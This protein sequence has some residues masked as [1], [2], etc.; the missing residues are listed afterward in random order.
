MEMFWFLSFS[1]EFHPRFNFSCCFYYYML[2]VQSKGFHYDISVHSYDILWSYSSHLLPSLI[3]PSSSNTPSNHLLTFMF[4]PSLP[5][6]PIGGKHDICLPE[7]GLFHLTYWFPVPS[8]FLQ[9]MQFHS[10]WLN[11]TALYRHTIFLYICWWE[12][13]LIL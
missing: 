7:F 13:R 4:S 11:N 6:V 3:L 8:I 9:M 1:Q 10:L 5:R 12:P 2:I